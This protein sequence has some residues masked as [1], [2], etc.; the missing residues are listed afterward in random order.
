[1]DGYRNDCK[2]CNLA[3][4]KRRY[5]ADPKLAIARV[6]AWRRRNPEKY[7]A[8]LR[9]NLAANNGRRRKKEREG[10]LRR[11]YG[12]TAAEYDFLV[13]TQSNRCA[14]CGR[15]DPRG[16]HVD[17]EHQTGAIRGLLCGSCNRGLGLFGEDPKRLS[18]AQVYL[19]RKQ[20][21]L[22]AGGKHTG[23]P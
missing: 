9:K 17:H 12:L 15:Q 6:Q 23:K 3:A 2:V 21:P 7:K 20:F 22:G 11:M 13:Q 10:H 5:E 16:L 14:I 1:R 19:S 4:K 8:W 18:Q